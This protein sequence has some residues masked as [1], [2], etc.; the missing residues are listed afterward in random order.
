MKTKR[1][2]RTQ[3]HGVGIAAGVEVV[4]EVALIQSGQSRR[5]SLQCKDGQEAPVF[6][7][8]RDH[9]GVG[10]GD[11]KGQKDEDGS[12]VEGKTDSQVATEGLE[13]HLVNGREA[14][15]GFAPDACQTMKA[16]AA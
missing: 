10:D 7:L 11:R 16:A 14:L 5:K 1:E 2:H 15:F 8:R 3:G 13:L 6:L 12:I 9:V 4:G